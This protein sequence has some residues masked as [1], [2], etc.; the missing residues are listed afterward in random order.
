MTLVGTASLTS[1]GLIIFADPKKI[2]SNQ[3]QV[4]FLKFVDQI[5]IDKTAFSSSSSSM[6]LLWIEKRKFLFY[7]ASRDN[8][9]FD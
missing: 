5:R 7:C 1:I 3:I 2:E 6:C 9:F 4:D 8:N